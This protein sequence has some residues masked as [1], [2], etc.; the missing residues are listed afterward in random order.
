MSKLVSIQEFKEGQILTQPIKNLFGQV[1][2]A[3]P[4]FHVSKPAFKETIEIA[5]KF[6]L[7]YI[8]GP[9]VFFSRTAVLKKG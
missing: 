8:K 9:N 3:E 2:I 5:N 1:L 7:T 4:P 6:G